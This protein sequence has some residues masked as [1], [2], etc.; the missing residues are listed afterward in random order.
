MWYFVYLFLE[1][2]R[3]VPTHTNQLHQQQQRQIKYTNNFVDCSFAV[4]YSDFGLCMNWQ[5]ILAKG[6]NTILCK[7]KQKKNI[8]IYMGRRQQQQKMLSARLNLLQCIFIYA[9][10]LTRCRLRI[11]KVW[12]C[13][14]L[15]QILI[16][17]A[18]R[19]VNFFHQRYWIASSSTTIILKINLI[20]SRVLFLFH[21]R[22]SIC[23]ICCP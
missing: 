22:L 19:H 13:L 5:F 17:E 15:L 4:G 6:S 14:V 7:H 3:C 16:F 1:N 23:S 18:A 12:E 2:V 9:Q 20:F 10:C 21:M 11:C 8:L